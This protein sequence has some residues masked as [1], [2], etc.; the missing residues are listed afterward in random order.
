MMAVTTVAAKPAVV[1]TAVVAATI[2]R[3]RINLHTAEGRIAATVVA[4]I[5]VASTVTSIP[6]I[7]VLAIASAITSAE[8]VVAVAIVERNSK[9]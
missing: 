1:A 3:R 8:I 6:A 4:T 2:D 5:A 9:P 7:I